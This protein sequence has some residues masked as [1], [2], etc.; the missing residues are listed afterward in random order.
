MAW[1]RGWSGQ[2]RPDLL[3]LVVDGNAETRSTVMALV[4]TFGLEVR[5]AEDGETAYRLVLDRPPDLI[6]CDLETPALDGFVR[7]LRR[8]PRLPRLLTVAVSAPARPVDATKTRGLGFDGHVSRPV[9]P[10]GLAR[11]LDR[12]LDQQNARDRPKGA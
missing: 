12:A 4:G 3:V 9:A 2:R 5:G 7:R 1:I 11:L 6:L 8:D 10:E